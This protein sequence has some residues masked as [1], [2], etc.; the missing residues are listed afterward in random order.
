MGRCRYYKDPNNCAQCSS[1]GLSCSWTF[2]DQLEENSDLVAFFKNTVTPK[3]ESVVEEIPDPQW[4]FQSV[5]N[6]G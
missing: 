5:K 1:A 2:V 6:E 4:A 3:A